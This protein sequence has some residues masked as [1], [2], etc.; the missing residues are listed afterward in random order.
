MIELQVPELNMYAVSNII[1]IDTGELIDWNTLNKYGDSINVVEEF[2]KLNDAIIPIRE[3]K[4]FE[5][6]ART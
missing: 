4:H 1:P 2:I 5:I 3:K 6:P